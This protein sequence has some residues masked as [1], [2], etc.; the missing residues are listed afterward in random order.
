MLVRWRGME[1][2]HQVQVDQDTYSES[3]GKFMVEPFERGFGTTV[4]NSLR[5]ILLSSLE[6]SA[7]SAVKISGAPHEFCSL[8]GVTEDVTDII[9]NIKNL[10]VSMDCDEPKVMR[11][12]AVGP[13]DVSAALIEADP[14][15][16][17]HNPDLHIASLTKEV[18]LE[19]EFHV[20]K[21]RG[22]VPASERYDPSIDQEVGL[23]YV[24]ATYS[25]VQ[26][27]RYKVE[28]TR[29]GQRTNYDKLNLEI[30][31]NGTVVP[32]L[33]MVE[34]AKIMRKHLNPFIE[35]QDASA[36][37]AE[38]IEP[39]EEEVE[40]EEEVVE[41]NPALSMSVSDLGLSVRPSNCLE[42]AGINLVRDLVVMNEDEMMQLRSFGE[43]SL[44]EVREKLEELGLRIGMIL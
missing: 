43:T 36:E 13:G 21:G 3:Y 12:S 15:I 2:P 40:I 5:R 10:I 18:D 23:I 42:G 31:T 16:T 22:Y 32:E 33:A 6:G 7:V 39:L 20:E 44:V 11:L 37:T 34:A 19:I 30:W 4:G 35:Y 14:A 41:E 8:E 38:Q 9:L 26:R 1:L 17:I 25:P 27:V 29:V 24:D 28:D